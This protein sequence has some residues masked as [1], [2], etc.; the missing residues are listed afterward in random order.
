MTDSTKPVKPYILGVAGGSGSGKTYFA[1]DIKT[2]LKDKCS[3][4]LQDNFYIDQSKNFDYDGG[5]VNFDHPSSIDHLLL[6][7][8]LFELKK[9]KSVA[10]PTYDFKTHTRTDKTITIEPTPIVIVDGILI[11]HWKEVREQFDELIYFNTEEHLRFERRLRRDVEERGREP[12]GVRNQ[13][14]KQV[15]PMHDEFVE[16]SSKFA[17]RIVSEKDNYHEVVKETLQK[18]SAIN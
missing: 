18:L 11:F 7:N 9:G 17:T 6:A 8:L 1:N 4:I 13:F 12:E 10:I 5:S 14:I 3:V 15:K 16:P 2:H